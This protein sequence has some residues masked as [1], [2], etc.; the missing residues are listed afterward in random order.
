MAIITVGTGG[1]IVKREGRKGSRMQKK[2]IKNFCYTSE[3][4]L[5]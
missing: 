3:R 4:G 2:E 1:Y 5:F